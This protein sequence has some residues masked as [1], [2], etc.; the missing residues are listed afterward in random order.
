MHPPSPQQFSW[1]QRPLNIIINIIFINII[2]DT[3]NV[4]VRLLRE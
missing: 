2:L 3:A 4:P 1:D